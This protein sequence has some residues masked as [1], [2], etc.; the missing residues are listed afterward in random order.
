MTFEESGNSSCLQQVEEDTDPGHVYSPS[1]F[2]P[3]DPMIFGLGH[4]WVTDPWVLNPWVL[5]HELLTDSFPLYSE[6]S[7]SREGEGKNT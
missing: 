6:I 7:F 3:V 5:T 2:M 4:A 1:G